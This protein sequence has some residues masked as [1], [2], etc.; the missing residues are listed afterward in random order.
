MNTILIVILM[1]LCFINYTYS[2]IFV[3]VGPSGSGKSTLISKLRMQ[4]LQFDDL[5]SHTTRPMRSSETHGKDYFFINKNEYEKKEQNNEFMMSTIVHGNLYG[6]SKGYID[7]KIQQ[8]CNVICSLNTEATKKLKNM[9]GEKIVTIFITPPSFTEL[10]TRLFKR[11]L[12]NKTALKTRI[13]NA[14]HELKEQ[15]SFD[16]KIIN[17]N[18][19]IS[20]ENLKKIFLSEIT[21]ELLIKQS[22]IPLADVQAIRAMSYNIRMAPFAEDD[23]T[24]ND[25]SHRLPKINMILNRYVP[26][27]IGIQEVSEFQMNSFKNSSYTITYEF[28]G[29]YPTKKPIESGLGIFYNPQKL[30][31]ISQTYI[32]WLNEHQHTADAPAWDGSSYERYV[33]YAKFKNIETNEDFWFMTTHF[34]HLG[35]KARQESAKIIMNLA[36]NLDAPVII[37]GDFNCFPQLGGQELYQT[38][39]TYS[40]K[41]K[42]SGTIS[43]MLFGVP[44][45]WMGWDY[46]F[47]KLRNSFV[48]YDF[49][50]TTQTIQIIQH[51]IIDDQVW[52]KKF[53]KELY[54]SDHRPVLTDLYIH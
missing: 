37:T 48:K 25:W 32:C 8:N 34:D 6:I 3:L 17:D 50:F 20:V 2:Q 39:C 12:E 42:D 43:P 11:N 13:A 31:L 7:T 1:N 22:V 18:L 45:T 21:L 49:I 15:D 9:F 5:I 26:D 38:L 54:P 23:G 36:E 47:Y 4:G 24:E 51:G 14:K 19:D 40:H 10:K 46:D 52:D 29:K 53:Q 30:A 27:I 28:L 33:M 16:Y 44:G 41:I 35:I